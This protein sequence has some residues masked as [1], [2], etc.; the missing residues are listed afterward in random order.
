MRSFAY[1]H[2]DILD[3]SGFVQEL[4]A[5]ALFEAGPVALE[6]VIDPDGFHIGS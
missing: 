1:G 5:F 3:P 6:T 4:V 2:L